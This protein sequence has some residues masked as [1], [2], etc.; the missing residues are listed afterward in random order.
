MKLQSSKTYGGAVLAIL[1]LLCSCASDVESWNR[2]DV[3]CNYY[4][5]NQFEDA[6]STLH[7]EISVNSNNH[8]AFYELGRNFYAMKKY[9][10]AG[11]AFDHALEINPRHVQ[12]MWYK[13]KLYNMGKKYRAAEKIL[14]TALTYDDAEAADIL[15]ELGLTYIYLENYNE[16][17]KIFIRALEKDSGHEDVK[18]NLDMALRKKSAAQ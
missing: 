7:Q 8:M 5:M 1:F 9:D 18:L 3:A 14:K 2:V 10:D 12:S 4:N 17:E 11:R 6:V 16:A 15:N 13:G